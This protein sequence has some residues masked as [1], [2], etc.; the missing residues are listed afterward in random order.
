VIAEELLASSP[1]I[2][3]GS[4]PQV[5]LYCLYGEDALEDGQNEDPL[6]HQAATG[7]WTLALPC[8]K[9]DEAWIAAELAVHG[10]RFS[11]YVSE[12]NA[13]SAA[14]SNQ[15]E[16]SPPQVDWKEFQKA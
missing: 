11:C 4:G 9:E 14:L 16:V 6:T 3:S 12:A 2:V 5:R 13:K 10:G 15:E 1:I 8:S 7:T